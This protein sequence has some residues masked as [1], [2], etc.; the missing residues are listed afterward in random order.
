MNQVR[1]MILVLAGVAL[2]GCRS[3]DFKVHDSRLY[4]SGKP[5]ESTTDTY[6]N[7]KQVSSHSVEYFENGRLRTDEWRGPHGPLFKLT[8]YETGRLKS[9]ERYFNG[10]LIYGVYYSQAGDVERTV[11]KLTD[12]IAKPN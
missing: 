4:D 2:C 3:N 9:E 5:R 10:E 8:F 7:G 12:A 1:W 6:A 11:G